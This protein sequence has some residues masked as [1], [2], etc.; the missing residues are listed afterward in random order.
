[1]SDLVVAANR[2]PFSLAE[3]PGGGVVAKPA[4]G[5]LAPSLASALAGSGYEAVWVASAMNA[6]ER[7]ASSSGPIDSEQKGLALRFVDLDPATYS[8]AYDVVA[9]ATLWFCYHGMFDAPRRPVFDARG[10]S[11]GRGSAPTTPRSPTGS[12]TR[13]TRRHGSS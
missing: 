13:R 4:G 11:R 9:N 2:G 10:G 5:G 12:A 7:R 6:V 3:E 1:M 8:A